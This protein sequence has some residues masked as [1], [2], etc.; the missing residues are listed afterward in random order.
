MMADQPYGS[1][2]REIELHEKRTVGGRGGVN[3]VVL[4][5]R[6]KAVVF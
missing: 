6:K 4:N 2:P 3:Y 5:R 1:A